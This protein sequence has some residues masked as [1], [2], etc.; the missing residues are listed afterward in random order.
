MKYIFLVAIIINVLFNTNARDMMPLKLLKYTVETK[1][2]NDTYLQVFF[3]DK[4]K[5]EQQ[6]ECNFRLMNN[7]I[8]FSKEFTMEYKK[9]VPKPIQITA[10]NY[11]F[12]FRTFTLQRLDIKKNKLNKVYITLE[13]GFLTCSYFEN[14]DKEV[15]YDI[16]IRK[17]GN[18]T[19]SLIK[20]CN[21]IISLEPAKYIVEIKSTPAYFYNTEIHM[22]GTTELQIKEEGTLK[23]GLN[24]DEK[25]DVEILFQNGSGYSTLMNKTLDKKNRV[26]E[27]L[28][29]PRSYKVVAKIYTSNGKTET[30]TSK[31]FKIN[32]N[33]EYK[34][35][36]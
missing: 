17:K 1:D 3:V 13:N 4:Q 23:L 21:E 36:Y 29:A 18:K 33:E 8:N 25:A 10:S 7:D 5:N 32:S 30:I 9:G 14:N 26:V 24:N 34:I 27:I 35:D 28:L 20:K 6:W 16:I 19:D 15:R 12:Y 2:S 22:D 11:T 31:D